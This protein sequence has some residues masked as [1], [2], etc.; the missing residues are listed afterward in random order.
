M[1]EEGHQKQREAVLVSLLTGND[2]KKY[3]DPAAA[4]K[5]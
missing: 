5:K 3:A 2:A 1:S 4:F